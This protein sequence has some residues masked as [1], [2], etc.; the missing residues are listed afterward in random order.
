MSDFYQGEI[1]VR[2]G[3]LIGVVIVVDDR[4]KAN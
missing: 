3:V 4:L 2:S 1:F